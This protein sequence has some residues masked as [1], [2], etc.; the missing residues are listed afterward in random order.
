MG[1]TA[2]PQ[3]GFGGLVRQLRLKLDLSQDEVAQQVGITGSYLARIE[4][5]KLVPNRSLV[6]QLARV[7]GVPALAL[8]EAGG[9]VPQEIA[10]AWTETPEALI[11]FSS[12]PASARNRIMREG[13]GS[14]DAD[15]KERARLRALARR[16]ADP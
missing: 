6:E 2:N 1:R 7:L 8:M 14:D 10:N 13:A 11:W 5:N 15:R 16:L 9:Y 4:L 12:L 3:T